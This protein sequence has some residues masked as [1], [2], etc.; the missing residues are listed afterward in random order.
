M[1]ADVFEIIIY[2]LQFLIVVGVVLSAVLQIFTLPGTVIQF[3]L[4]LLYSALTDFQ[5]VSYGNI[6]FFAILALV[7]VLIDNIANLLGAKKFGASKWG[8]L[9]AFLGGLLS[10]I[11]MQLWA[12]L[13]IPFL[14]AILFEIAFDRREWKSALKAGF[15]SLVGFLSGYLVRIVIAVIN[16]IV[17]LVLISQQIF[18]PAL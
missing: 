16:V 1:W 2:I 13:F 10:M 18:L 9:G 8:V 3:V 7:S 17:F 12:I 4:I 5:S 11:F 15:G 6:I 14:G